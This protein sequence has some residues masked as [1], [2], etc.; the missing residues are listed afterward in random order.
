MDYIYSILTLTGI[1]MIG[2]MGTY[3]VTGLTGQF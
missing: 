2:V 3:L 1:T